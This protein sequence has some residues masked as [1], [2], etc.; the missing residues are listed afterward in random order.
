M[1]HS[2]QALKRARTSQIAREKN[3]SMR[4]AVKSAVKKVSKITDAASRKEIVSEADKKI[5]KAAQK[6]S[7]HKNTARRLRS[8]MA[9]RANALTKSKA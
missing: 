1:A 7:L 6:G 9:K 3:R 2:K 8:R 4:S 5:D